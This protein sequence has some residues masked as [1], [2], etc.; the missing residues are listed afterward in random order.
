V[1]LECKRIHL[2]CL[3][4]ERILKLLLKLQLMAP[5]RYPKICYERLRRIDLGD[6]QADSNSAFN[7]AS[8]CR[9]MLEQIGMSYVWIH[10]SPQVLSQRYNQIVQSFKDQSMQRDYTELPKRISYD[11]YERFR[12]VQ[13]SGT[14]FIL[15]TPEMS[16]SS[17]SLILQLR[18]NGNCLY[19]RK[20]RYDFQQTQVCSYCNL[21]QA[22]T[23]QHF[24]FDCPIHASSRNNHLR[25]QQKYLFYRMIDSSHIDTL[26]NI[27]KFVKES[28]SRLKLL[29][30]LE[31]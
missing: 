6:G 10:M 23:F 31:N 29:I 14:P 16:Y 2:E 4:K 28:L 26:N 30:E 24:I 11:Y 9:Q 7:W 22:N 27:A 17:R 13:V 1:R 3:V 12:H 19:F 5:E 18:L 21:N 20:H 8:Q 25:H 15:T